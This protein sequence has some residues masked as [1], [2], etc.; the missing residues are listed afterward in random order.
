MA[1]KVLRAGLSGPEMARRFERECQTL[2][3]LVHP[4]IAQVH[5]AGV[6]V[7][8]RP[9]VVL[10]Y[11]DGKPIHLFAREHRLDL[12]ARLQLFI[13]VCRAGEFA[14]QKGVIHRDL[15]PGN[16]LVTTVDGVPRPKVID[17]GIAKVVDDDEAARESLTELTLAGA[18]VGTPAYMS[19]EQA[20][21]GSDTLDTLPG[22]LNIADASVVRNRETWAGNAWEAL[23]DG[24]VIHAPVGTFPANPYG[25]H[26][27]LGNVC[28]WCLD[29]CGTYEGP[30]RAIE[31]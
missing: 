10:E 2:A 11:V 24:Y 21:S 26:E 14:H 25:L 16:I 18:V 27:T 30:A 19:P 1:L 20:L 15:K 28:E 17:F 6:T 8:G 5:D 3:R 4:G 29:R 7:D 22:H 23:D 12:A 31:R 13:D 9:Y